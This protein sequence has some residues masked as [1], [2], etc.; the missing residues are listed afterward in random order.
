MT[1]SEIVSGCSRDGVELRLTNDGMIRYSGE[2]YSL[3]YWLPI[4]AANKSSV[5]DELLSD[6]FAPEAKVIRRCQSC[7]HFFRPGMTDGHCGERDD[8]PHA[9]GPNHPLR[10][11][12]ADNG[13]SCEVW[14]IKP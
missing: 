3:K 5:V 1:P 9:Y 4:L 12:P 14:E 13:E 10:C 8:L 7:L 11:L 2:E 6:P